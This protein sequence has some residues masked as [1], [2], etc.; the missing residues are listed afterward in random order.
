MESKKKV[1]ER[2]GRST[3]EGDA[4]IMAWT[5][6]LKQENIPGGFAELRSRKMPQVLFGRAAQRR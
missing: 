4:V 3:D 1:C 6:G 2:L 5:K